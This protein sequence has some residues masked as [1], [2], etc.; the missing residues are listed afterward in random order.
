MLESKPVLLQKSQ[1]QYLLSI[2][3][4]FISTMIVSYL[5]VF[6]CVNPGKK[7]MEVKGYILCI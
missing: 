3:M 7:S 4:L 1:C 6:S 2:L 5:F